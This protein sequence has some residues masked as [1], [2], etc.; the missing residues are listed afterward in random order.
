MSNVP[1]RNALR[2]E[3][4]YEFPITGPF[5]GM[6]TELPIDQIENYGF[7][8]TTN[9]L[10]RLGAAQLRPGFTSLAAMPPPAEPVLGFADFYNSQAVRIQ[11]IFTPTRLL[12]WN[13]SGWT[14]ITGPALT[15]VA[16]QTFGWDVI[17]SKLCF[18]Q[19]TNQLMIWDG[20]ANSYALASA[21]APAAPYIAEIGLHLMMQNTIEGGQSFTQ[22]YHWSGI[23]D[24]TDWTSFSSGIN[25]NLNNLGPGL[26][27]LKLGQYG[28]GWHQWGL[29]QIQ[30]TGFGLAP[31][32][33]SPI[34]GSEVGNICAR[35]L[36][37]IN[38]NGVECAVYIGKDNVYLFNQSSVTP[39]GDAPIDGRRRVGARSGIF[40][41]LRAGTPSTVWGTIVTSIHGLP[42]NAYWIFIPGVSVW[43]YNFDEGNWT[44]F[45]YMNV[46]I[47]A[48]RF[49]AQLGIRIIDLIGTIRQQNWTPATL[50]PIN[51]F[52]GMGLGFNNGTVGYIDFTNY[53]E[54][55]GSITSG[56]HIFND[57]RHSKAVKKFRLVVQDRGPVVY[58]ITV[59]NNHGYSQ[60]Q[61]VSIGT[62]SGDSVSQVIEFTVPG[63]RIQWQVAVPP[64]SP[65]AIVE[66]CPI[67]DITG[68][69]RGGLID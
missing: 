2:A 9:F 34:V 41:D 6:Q 35:S 31:Y 19:G 52:D 33:F 25:D 45:S 61:V 13:G 64:N 66:F 30:P 55:A 67:Y 16:S 39:I 4:L 48:G 11:V 68:E 14:A 62:G 43:V 1:D 24:P 29:L 59:W 65:A 51:P 69:Q 42:Y 57:R 44:R 63:M 10:F 37:K 56:K 32:V 20:I 5:G 21:S 54:V 28:Y 50:N 23:G 8:D 7:L 27:L 26:G 58:T 18:S 12:Q 36:Q 49:F 60:S 47:T 46:P 22:R 38:L 53:S 17:N 3:E 40:N 15:G